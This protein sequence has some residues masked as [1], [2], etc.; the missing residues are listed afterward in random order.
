MRERG[1]LEAVC[2]ACE[3]V[4]DRLMASQKYCGRECSALARV[5]RVCESSKRRLEE[6]YTPNEGEKAWIEARYQEALRENREAGR[7]RVETGFEGYRS[8]LADL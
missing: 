1:Q 7:F 4:F 2:P 6:P 3:R 8:G 5:R